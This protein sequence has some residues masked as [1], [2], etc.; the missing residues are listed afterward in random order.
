MGNWT[1]A[2]LRKSFLSAK[3][4]LWVDLRIALL[5]PQT[6]KARVSTLKTTFCC[7]VSSHLASPSTSYLRP[8]Y[9][10]WIPEPT[11]RLRNA[12]RLK[13]TLL[14]RSR[15]TCNRLWFAAC[16]PSATS[17]SPKATASVKSLAIVP[18]LAVALLLKLWQRL[19]TRAIQGQD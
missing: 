3:Q 8:T 10:I 1:P 9:R 2:R 17:S 5:W 12:I 6:T 13:T 7:M 4:V 15:S 19:S 16:G 11:I 14:R 18:C